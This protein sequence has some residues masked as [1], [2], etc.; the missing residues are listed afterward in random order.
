MDQRRLRRRALLAAG[1]AALGAATALS[2]CAG[3]G[4]GDDGN[5]DGGAD[6]DGTDASDGTAAGD[7]TATESGDDAATTEPPSAADLDLREAN[8]T[9]VDVEDRGDGEYRFSVTLYHD[10]DGEDGYADRWVVERRDG[11]ELGRREL[12]HAHSTAPFT[13][14]ETVAV[15]EGVDCVVVRGHDQTHGYGGRAA[16]VTL[17]GATSFHDQGPEPSSFADRDCP[18]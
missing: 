6:D 1:T 3:D 14:S 4:G 9:A 18:E 16:L 10:D 13:R 7:G 5:D 17:D 2:G 11:T 8:V 15:P 12:L